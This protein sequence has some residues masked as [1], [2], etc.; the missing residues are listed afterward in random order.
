MGFADDIRRFREK[1]LKDASDATN[2]VVRDLFTTVVDYSPTPSGKGGY[3]VG[4][5]KDNWYSSVM[6][7]DTSYSGSVSATGSS[8]LSRINSTLSQNPFKGRDNIV[9]LTNSTKWA[10]RADKLGWNK[11]DPD[12][13]TGW[14]WSGRIK[15]YHF[16]GNS[17]QAILNRWG[18]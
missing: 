4:T 1:A 8:S 14:D 16:T 18:T 10:F 7:P 13:D 5:I 6:N 17:I 9:Y 2:K 3:S 12:N 11:N 15:A